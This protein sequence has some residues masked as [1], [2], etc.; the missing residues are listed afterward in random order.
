MREKLN[1]DGDRL[2]RQIVQY[3][4]FSQ[5]VVELTKIVSDGMAVSEQIKLT[6]CQRVLG[7][8]CGVIQMS[9]ELGKDEVFSAAVRPLEGSRADRYL[10]GRGS[11]AS[12]GGSRAELSR[13]CAGVG[14]PGSRCSAMGGCGDV[15]IAT[16]AAD[17]RCVTGANVARLPPNIPEWLGAH[18]AVPHRVRD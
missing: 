13:Y 6:D 11:N 17:R 16:Y 10:S 8:W 12:V 9:V 4:A 15:S 18:R 7:T 1:N 2:H 14:L 5:S 3:G